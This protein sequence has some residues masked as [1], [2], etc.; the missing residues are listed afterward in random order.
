MLNLIITYFNPNWNI[1]LNFPEYVLEN[2]K[3]DV[4]QESN[5]FYLLQP[6]RIIYINL[7]S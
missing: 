4:T 3:S 2:F 7:D 6:H 1:L 5:L